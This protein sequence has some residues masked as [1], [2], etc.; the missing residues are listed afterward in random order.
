[1]QKINGRFQM[2]YI[3]DMHSKFCYACK[4]LKNAVDEYFS[5]SVFSIPSSIFDP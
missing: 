3:V 5:L 1:M 2:E 4:C